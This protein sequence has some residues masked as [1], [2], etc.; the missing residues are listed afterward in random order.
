MKKKNFQIIDN[1]GKRFNVKFLLK[2]TVPLNESPKTT[3]VD[4]A[5]TLSPN[6]GLV[7]Y[8]S[9]SKSYFLKNLDVSVATFALKP[10]VPGLSPAASYVQR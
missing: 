8:Y 9:R 10:E 2:K 4:Y 7:W 3:Q 6:F 1:N 5:K